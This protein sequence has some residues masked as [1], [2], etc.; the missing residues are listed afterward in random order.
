MEE[1]TPGKRLIIP[2]VLKKQEVFKKRKK[3]EGET[4][5]DT[6][7]GMGISQWSVKEQWGG[8]M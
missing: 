6:S 3:I 5:K 2:A 7:S 8:G 1:V 4:V